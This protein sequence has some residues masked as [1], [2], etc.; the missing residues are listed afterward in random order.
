[1][2]LITTLFVATQ[3]GILIGYALSRGYRVQVSA[4]LTQNAQIELILEPS[5]STQNSAGSWVTKKRRRGFRC[6]RRHRF[7][8][9]PGTTFVN[10][11][12]R[13]SFCDGVSPPQELIHNYCNSSGSF[14]INKQ[15][16]YCNSH[17]WIRI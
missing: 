12:R 6:L 16:N 15:I 10:F 8:F 3:I 7:S 4:T 17:F 14:R 1:M 2:E 9:Y 13:W 5:G 11:N